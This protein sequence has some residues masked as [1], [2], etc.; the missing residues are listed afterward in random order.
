MDSVLGAQIVGEYQSCV[1]SGYVEM[2]VSQNIWSKKLATPQ[3]QLSASYPGQ[4][5]L[6]ELAE[7]AWNRAR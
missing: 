3:V 2:K 1:H 6:S 5:A 4:L 7:E